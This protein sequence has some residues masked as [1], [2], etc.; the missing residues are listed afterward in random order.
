MSD[1]GSTERAEDGGAADPSATA[2]SGASPDDA[3][4]EAE[5]RRRVEEK[6]D[7]DE[8]GP[9][10]MA[11]MSAAEWDAAFDPDSWI[12]GEELIDRVERD[13]ERQIADREVFAVV[14][15]IAGGGLIAYSD[16]G[17]ALVAPDGSVEGVGT[18]LR[19]VKP[20]V[21]L[22]SMPDYEVTP[23]PEGVPLPTPGEVPEGSGELGNL[24][25]QTVAGVL[26]VTALTL[27]GGLVF[28]LISP[29]GDGSIG[30]IILGGTAAIFL[31]I[32]LVLFVTVAN[33]RLSDKFRAEEFRERLRAVGLED[34]DRPEFLPVRERE[35]DDGPPLAPAEP[36]AT[37]PGIDDDPTADDAA[38]ADDP[39]PDTS[40]AGDDRSP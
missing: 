10:Q 4:T 27:L 23:A 37:P 22:C 26:T 40:A 28:G 3:D 9:D 20:T 36:T 12:T 25:L 11:E 39:A 1:S 32:A 33:A 35:A 15:R 5:L 31:A 18:V 13:L 38:T 21:A 34:G 19:D 24:M 16:E 7:F 8:F 14:E 2:E 29:V 17:Y 6:Y 30:A